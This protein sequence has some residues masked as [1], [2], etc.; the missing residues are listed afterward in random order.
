MLIG[1]RHRRSAMGLR[2]PADARGL[3]DDPHRC[4]S[5]R[6]ANI[7]GAAMNEITNLDHRRRRQTRWQQHSL[8]EQ[9]ALEDLGLAI[10]RYLAQVSPE[11]INNAA[12]VDQALP[13]V[14]KIKHVFATAKPKR[15]SMLRNTLHV[16]AQ[17]ATNRHE[18][19]FWEIF[20]GMALL[21]W[22]KN[23]ENDP[24]LP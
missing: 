18:R 16:A 9:E 19:E 12:F 5:G 22:L 7:S 8:K 13:H 6:R 1:L 11:N 21:A 20:A 3:Q 10:E 23:S 2:S 15:L 14:E 4:C 24:S 17:T